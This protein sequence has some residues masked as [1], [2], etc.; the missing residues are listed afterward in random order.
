LRH[1]SARPKGVVLGEALLLFVKDKL[2]L[3]SKS[4]ETRE[5]LT[6]H[7]GPASKVLDIH[8]TRIAARGSRAYETLFRITHENLGR[9][10]EELPLRYSPV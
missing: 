2:L 3:L 9:M 1:L 6:V 8:K 10:L 4:P 7:F 5:H